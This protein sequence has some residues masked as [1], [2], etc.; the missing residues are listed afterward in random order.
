MMEQRSYF[1]LKCKGTTSEGYVSFKIDRVES[2]GMIEITI[3]N[4]GSSFES[5]ALMNYNSRK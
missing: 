3:E 2:Q 5:F 1:T 4:K